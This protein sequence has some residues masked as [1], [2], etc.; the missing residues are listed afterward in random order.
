MFINIRNHFSFS[1]AMFLLLIFSQN[2]FAT[3]IYQWQDSEGVMHFSDQPQSDNAVLVS[4]EHPQDKTIYR[5]EDE[6]GVMQYGQEMPSELTAN[7]HQVQLVDTQQQDINEDR[8]SILNQ[9]QRMQEQRAKVE[10]TRLE[11]DRLAFEAYQLAQEQETL[12]VLEMIRKQGYGPRPYRQAYFQSAN[13][14]GLIY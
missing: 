8:Y 13:N 14:F 6:A 7:L 5:W 11:A 10:Q 3:E 1:M 2:S 4:V 9:A 12:R